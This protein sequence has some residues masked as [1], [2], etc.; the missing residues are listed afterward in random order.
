MITSGTG[1][2][3]G[4]GRMTAVK[5]T[6]AV[7]VPIYDVEDYLRACLDSVLAQ[8]RRA[9]QV[10][11]VDDGSRDSSGAIADEYAAAHEGWQVVHVE[12]GGLGRARNIGADLAT[13]DYVA[14][15]D[16]DDVV[17]P[18]AYALLL[19]HLEQSGSDLAVGGVL[20]Y[21]GTS[22]MPSPL[23]Q[24][25]IRG[26]ELGT[27]ISRNRNL[28]YDTTA[29][30]KVFRMEFWRR[31]KLR[32]PEGVFYEDIPV[33]IPAHFLAKSVDVVE[34]PV[35]W[36]RERQTTTLS[37]TQRRHEV[38]NFVDRMAA[39]NA[40]ETFLA[41]KKL[42]ED[43]ALHE[44][45]V[46]TIDLRL[47]LPALLEATDEFRTVFVELAGAF[48][49]Q[50]DEKVLRELPPA[51]RLV[52]WL[53]GHGHLP[54]LLEVIEQQVLRTLDR[55]VTRRPLR[56]TANLPYRDD[57]AL[58]VPGWVY[59]VTNSQP[60]RA[61]VDDARWEGQALVLEG[62]AFVEQVPMTRRWASRLRI[63]A[64]DRATARSFFLPVTRVRDEEQTGAT[65]STPTEYTW[66][67]FVTDVDVATLAA[68]STER[69]SRYHFLAHLTT[70]SARRG[71]GMRVVRLGRGATPGAR[72]LPDGTL[73]VAGWSENGLELAV[74]RDP[75]YLRSVEADGKDLV[76]GIRL[77]AR[78]RR[79]ADAGRLDVVLSRAGAQDVRL[80]VPSSGRTVLPTADLEPR[81]PGVPVADWSVRLVTRGEKDGDQAG[82]P[83]PL[84]AGPDAGETAL[85]HGDGEL[86]V[87]V[88]FDGF[89][90]VRDASVTPRTD[91]VTFEDGHLV[92]SGTATGP[93]SGP[94][95]LVQQL[96][97]VPYP[98]EQDAD[99]HRWTVRVPLDGEP[100]STS[101][102]RLQAG[103]Y[104]LRC[105]E[106]AVE[107]ADRPLRLTGDL[108]GA[109]RS[110]A[111][112]VA[113]V[114]VEVGWNRNRQL[115]LEVDPG[116]PWPE[117]GAANHRRNAGPVYEAA[118]RA[119]LTGTVLFE[120]W[121]G[122]QFSDSPRAVYEELAA[123]DGDR[124][125]VWAVDSY[126]VEVP[127]GVEVVLRR[128]AEYYRTLGTAAAIV[129][130]DSLDKTFVKRPG[131]V[132]V[133]TWHGTPLKKIAHDISVARFSNRSY[134]AEFAR[135]VEAWDL[136]V[137]PNEFCSDVLPKAFRY[138]GDVL[139]AGYPRNDVFHHDAERERRAAAARA[140]LGLDDGRT[141]VLYAPTWRETKY[142]AAGSYLFD[143][144][145]DLEHLN[146][147]L[148]DDAVVLV[149]GHQLVADSLSNLPFPRFVRNASHYPDI[150]DLY[151]VADVLVTDYSS[152][153]FDFAN[154]GRPMLFFAYDLEQY[155]DELRGFYFD[156]L[157]EVPGPVVTD[158]AEV[159]ER[160][161]ALVA[162]PAAH[163]A[164]H[165]DRYR[166]FRQRFCGREDGKA[167][168]R[169]ADALLARLEARG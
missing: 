82:L 137:S 12:N 21:D 13:T 160:L 84:T 15:L 138:T 105:P 93:V 53:V 98:L 30:N 133:Q 123:R 29:W 148:A 119:P 94:V 91:A 154:T 134:L 43:K 58:G 5:S 110:V 151:L 122:R 9:D 70:L 116:G 37:I 96:N 101:L 150:Q 135:D 60:M 141:V 23:H 90:H 159:T 88:D 80:E 104:W 108:P 166:A 112:T 149:R 155:R 18:A 120:A 168:A 117:R 163:E 97:V 25:A 72:L 44:R 24:R 103:R 7:V 165:A 74:H 69:T 169:V 11:L 140:R 100:G 73:A 130:N 17:P 81:R 89:V 152:V 78:D 55:T 51:D 118:R 167:A 85:R 111:T 59:D 157:A 162:D 139:D 156:Y 28:L 33:T 52:W 153:M 71:R 26:T 136:L 10:V 32:F 66:C 143:M 65:K 102:R 109:R 42:D 106:P 3:G 41:G 8:T 68:A 92:L 27:H 107:A 75:T 2:G 16:S 6:L 126:G 63:E 129:S 34:D 131:Q 46:L 20:R 164:E 57:K 99:T 158:A 48:V 35:Y 127:D 50:A 49:R 1:G 19:E 22:L 95:S 14:F 83:V 79:A 76:L 40:V 161:K 121:K 132:Y 61:Q 77:G 47:Y 62:H 142:D 39:I 87:E 54:Q 113:G 4:D 128:S 144:R 31:E 146:A 67:G 36:W 115:T 45:K 125:L 38:P 147:D 86:A 145:L 64:R 114:G 124:R 56:L